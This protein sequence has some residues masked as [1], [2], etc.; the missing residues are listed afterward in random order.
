MVA[1][2]QV[3]LDRDVHR[4]ARERAD[5]LGISFAEYV[6][7]LV[8]DDL[9]DGIAAADRDAIFDLFDSGGSDVA[10]EKDSMIAAAVDDVRGR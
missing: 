1:R 8:A 10:A 3:T 4:R 2:T 7:R 6:R 5:Q 9:S